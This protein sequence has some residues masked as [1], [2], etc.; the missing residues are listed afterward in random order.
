MREWQPIETA[1]KDGTAILVWFDFAT[2][3]IVHIAWYRSAEEWENS[4]Q[5]CGWGTFKDWI[6][7][8]CYPE[9]SITQ[10]KLEGP[11]NPT[12]WM[13]LPEPPK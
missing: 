12:H 8:W 1:P 7:W 3:S 13:P 6:G 9:H 11:T 10:K 4:G 2:V 5:Y